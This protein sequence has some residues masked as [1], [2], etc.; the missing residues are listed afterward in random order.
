MVC[1]ACGVTVM[2]VGIFCPRC[3][4]H[5]LAQAGGESVPA[6]TSYARQMYM[7]PPRVEPNLHALGVLWCIYG[8]FRAIGGLIGMFFLQLAAMGGWIGRGMN[9][10]WPYSNHWHHGPAWLAMLVPFVGIYTVL[11]AGL[12]LLVGYGLLS[13]RPWGRTLA[14]IA[15]ILALFKP[16][17]GTALGVY[18]LWVLAP[19]RSGV[20]FDAIADRS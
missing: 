13:R 2:A 15:G 8:A 18:T 14:I 20:E 7:A 12:A 6:G 19:S 11:M 1:P 4:A 17:L 5:V 9:N 10:G 3:G 16:L